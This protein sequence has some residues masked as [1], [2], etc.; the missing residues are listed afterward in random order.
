MLYN[1]KLRTMENLKSKTDTNKSVSEKKETFDV[2]GLSCSSCANTV[3]RTLSR[4]EGVQ[5]ADVNY[6]YSASSA[7]VEYDPTVVGPD[8]MQEAVEKVG[9]KLNTKGSGK[10]DKPD[11]RDC[12]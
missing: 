9:Y 6:N 4:L 12:C 5:S 3:Q 7:T 2:G 11:R 8:Q 10:E 1:I